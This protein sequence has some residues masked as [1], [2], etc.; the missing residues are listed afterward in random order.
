MPDQPRLNRTV[1]VGGGIAG[2]TL[3]HALGRLSPRTLGALTLFERAPRFEEAGAGLQLGPNAS[4]LLIR[5]GLGQALA[6]VGCEPT[7]LVVC[8]STR[9]ET[10]AVKPLGRE[11]VEKY[12]APTYT[13]HRADLH[14]LL[15][16]AVRRDGRTSLALNREI[17][18]VR[19][20]SDHVLSLTVQAPEGSATEMREADLL[21]GC[22]GGFSA[23]RD[24][25]LG[26]GV[27]QA[28]GQVAFRAL[29]PLKDLNLGATAQ[30]V[31]AWLGPDMHAVGYPVRAGQLY[32]LVVILQVPL[33]QIDRRWEQRQVISVLPHVSVKHKTL[34]H[35]VDSVEQWRSWALFDRPPV[36]G[37]RELAP[38][39]GVLLLGD[40][41]HP[42]LPFLAQGAAMA[43]ED[44]CVIAQRC[45]TLTALNPAKNYTSLAA[46]YTQQRLR[47]VARVQAGARRNATLFHASGP[48]ALARN[49]ALKIN[50]AALLDRPWL[51]G[52]Q[53]P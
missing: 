36:R 29:L 51:Y 53:T 26:D 3:A 19:L 20:N 27:P 41:A 50:G 46:Y 42:M 10:L 28:T 18:A 45:A 24:L 13:V 31:T 30:C 21:L 11:C 5:L 16:E 38:H 44:A 9:T 40:A 22:D 32:N 17:S 39:P 23:V 15:L 7:S 34:A 25:L 43:I 37:P 48:V 33:A 2:L 35:L 52:Y 47:R 6:A 49:L 8:S 1:I 4:R 14:A 12:G